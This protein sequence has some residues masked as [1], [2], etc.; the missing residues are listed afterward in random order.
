MNIV[1]ILNGIGHL[2]F[3]TMLFWCFIGLFLIDKYKTKHPW[4]LFVILSVA[5]CTPIPNLL[6]FGLCKMPHFLFYAYLGYVFYE[7]KDVLYAKLRNK[8][9]YF[10][11]F[12]V[13][14]IIFY[15][16]IL[17]CLRQSV[18]DLVFVDRMLSLVGRGTHYL[19]AVSGITFLYMLV[20]RFLETKGQGYTLP[21]WVTASNKM[22]YGVYV[23]HQFLLQYLYY[24]TSM[25]AKLNSYLLPILA[26]VMVLLLSVLLSKLFVLTKVGRFLIG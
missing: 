7:N 23:F 19:M 5:S 6:S 26:F 1:E 15:Y 9:I 2:W 16:G 21:L 10:L 11:L 13:C 25:P 8:Y 12:Y 24:D 17:V 18:S 14:L 4:I 20:M 22:C 3:L